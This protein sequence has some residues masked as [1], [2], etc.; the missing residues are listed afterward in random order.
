VTRL[1]ALLAACIVAAG[2]AANPAGSATAPG[3]E[4]T[5]F[6]A[7]SLRDALTAA[8]V[9]YTTAAGVRFTLSFDSSATLRTQI[10]GGAP[11][12]VFAS[13]DTTIPGALADAGLTRGGVT[14]FAKNRLVIAVPRDN[15]AAIQSPA[16]LA[17]AGVRIVAAGESVPI[18]GYAAAAIANLAA[19]P[20]Y[21]PGFAA[22]VAAN[23]VS[24][25][26]NV[27]AALAKVELGEADAAIVYATDIRASTAAMSVELPP[28]ANV[29]VTYGAVVIKATS[30]PGPAA[31][32]VAWLASPDGNAILGRFG[33]LPPSAA[34]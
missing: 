24:R 2:C 34:G 13:A 8:T 25:E 17:G 20:G 18:S 5:I 14:I 30:R 4:L 12:D 27:R 31:A 3:A 26:D 29:M 9:A 23:T 10:E 6:G 7:A 16:D 15:A 33:F 21:P 22:S 32:F 28:E 1:R 11:A 19:L